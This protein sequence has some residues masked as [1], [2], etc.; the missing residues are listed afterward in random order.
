MLTAGGNYEASLLL[1][2][3]IWSGLEKEV[4]GEVV[5]SVPTRDL[6]VVTGSG[7]SAGLERIK[8][9]AKDA[10]GRLSYRLTPKLFVYRNGKFEEFTEGDQA[11]ALAA[12]SHPSGSEATD[13]VPPVVKVDNKHQMMNYPAGTNPETYRVPSASSMILDATGYTFDIPPALRKEALN[14][15]QVVQSRTH[16]FELAWQ[17]G[18]TRYELSKATLRPLPGSRPFEGFKGGD[19]LAVAIGVVLAPRKFAPVWTSIVKVE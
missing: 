16:Q 19:E 12:A 17:P 10:S 8:R 1:L 18:T 9:L 6:L 7:D 3:S 4:I 5:V 15:I 14:A 13:R 2:D 11:K